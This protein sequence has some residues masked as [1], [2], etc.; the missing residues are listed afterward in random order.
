MSMHSTTA[1]GAPPR[2]QAGP[3]PAKAAEPAAKTRSARKPFMILGVLAVIV[4]SAVGGYALYS[5]NR[6]STDDAQIESD[7]VP[8]SARVGSEV[9]VVHVKDNQPVKKGDLLVELDDNDL[10]ARVKQ[11][12]AGLATAKAQAN[13]ADA[14]VTVAEATAKGGLTT[15]KAG[16]YGSNEQVS[17]ASSQIAAAEAGLKRAQADATKSALDL[18]RV[19]QLAERGAV[20]QQQL[21][22]AVAVDAS[23]RAAV[24]QAEA[25]L[26]AAK[27]AKRVARSRVAEAVGRLD[28]SK[29]IDSQ[30]AIAKAND[31]LA[32][33][34]VKSAEAEL[35]LAKLQLS[36]TRIT[37][38]DDGVVSRVSVHAGQLVQPGQPI[39]EFVP[40][41]TYVI[42]NFKETQVGR[43]K[44]GD[45]AEIDIDAY[46]GKSFEGVVES[47]SAATGAR[48]ALMPPDNAS[49]NFVKVV[50]RVPVRIRWDKPPDRA[51]RAGLSADVTV[52]VG[53]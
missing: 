25:Q 47:L 32:H 9:R 23:A 46:P 13:A 34:R 28:Q 5:A 3:A 16:V 29:P 12:E 49:G 20:A 31:A 38:P 50:Q 21:D 35:E 15:A 44:A 1:E 19:Q 39:A 2:D 11:A 52:F 26:S 42:A 18:K 36:Y 24:D 22:N 17:S 27:Q 37:A 30:I 6:E 41:G 10:S 33:A 14:Q 48:F 8:V 4:L 7:V 51:M 40:K 53:H 45:R 43:I